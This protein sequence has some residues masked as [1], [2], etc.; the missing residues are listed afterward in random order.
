MKAREYD[1]RIEVYEITSVQDEFYGNTVTPTLVASSWAKLQ[2]GGLSH[3]AKDFGLQEFNEPLYFRLRYRKDLIYKPAKMYLMYLG[4]KY[5][6]QGI[7][8]VD[9]RKIEIEIFCSRQEV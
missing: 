4:E 8:D 6:I 2:T 5:I 7:E 1:K 3:K 9:K